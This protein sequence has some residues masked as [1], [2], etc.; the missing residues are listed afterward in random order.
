MDPNA[1]IE[2]AL[3][4][5]VVD[6]DAAGGPPRLAAA[7]RHAVFPGGARVRPQL[8]LAV[9][10]AC[11]E[12][13]NAEGDAAAA[14]GAAVALELLHCA[15]LVHD[16]LPCFDAADLRR[17][18]PSVHVRFGEPLA[19][20][21]GDALIVLAF[22]TLG[23]ACAVAP[24][25]LAP[26]LAVVGR[27]VGSP[28]GI[29][30][31]QAW[32]SEEEIDLRAYHQAKTGALFVGACAAGAA[33]MGVDPT[34]WTPL[35]ARLGEAYQIADDLRDHVMNAEELGKPA[36]QDDLND[37]P[38]AVRAFGVKGALEQLRALID[39]AAMSVPD[40]PGAEDLRGLV[41]AQARRLTPK[42]LQ[43]AEA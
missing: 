18:K 4:R 23:K 24:A 33:A 7:V 30:A 5:A 41:Y 20:L 38:S 2:G 43:A 8:C 12:L 36:G 10:N 22:E 42:S 39:D 34:G 3:E 27:A 14:V 1:L 31:G 21:A 26:L 6:T 11:R 25:R 28:A 17:G 29:V 40:C 15:S 13:D 16:D 37:R 35:G 19:L 9:A 32:E